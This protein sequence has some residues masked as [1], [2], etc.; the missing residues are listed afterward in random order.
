MFPYHL[1]WDRLLSKAGQGIFNVHNDFH[2]C[3]AQG[4]ETGTEECVQVLTEENW[5]IVLHPAPSS[6]RTLTTGFTGQRASHPA[7]CMPLN[8]S[9][10]LDACQLIHPVVSM[11][12]PEYIRLSRCMPVNTSGS[13]MMKWC[14]M[15][16]DVM[17]H[18]RDK[19]WPMPKHGAI[20]LY[21]H[22]NQKAR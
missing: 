11:H 4:G 5:K 9:G 2:V 13:L 6:S 21:V 7:T 1:P 16:S 12:A 3:C 22:G 15:S 14:F 10:C 8:I 18:I 19:L 20:N 17:R